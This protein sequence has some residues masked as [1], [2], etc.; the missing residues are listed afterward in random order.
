MPDL[1]P[2]LITIGFVFLASCSSEIATEP[3]QPSVSQQ[4]REQQPEQSTSQDA[5]E[6]TTTTASE[7]DDASANDLL[8]QA[9][10]ADD[11]AGV[12]DALERGADANYDIGYPIIHLA[13]E[14]ASRP[15]VEA[16]LEAGAD[17]NV[18]AIGG[19]S[20]LTR[21]ALAGNVAVIDALISGGADVEHR[22]AAP[23]RTV[24]QLVIDEAPSIEVM[25]AL[26]AAGADL[27]AVDDRGESAL[28][29]AAFMGRL[30]AAELLI[31]EGAAIDRV[32]NDGVSP[33]EWARRQ[34]N[35]EIVALLEAAGAAG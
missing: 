1:R 9:A 7:P 3:A 10:V 27:D 29:S 2:V 21:A 35:D 13:A 31:E 15:V 6:E 30:D 34:G 8:L 32:N 23:G 14:T 33:L 22:E 16:L 17:P 11:L 26:I 25:Q 28:A 4:E 20:A 5:A 12:L 24:L 18:S 19:Q